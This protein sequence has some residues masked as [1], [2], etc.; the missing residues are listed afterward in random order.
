M[1]TLDSA[2]L[3]GTAPIAP[4]YAVAAPTQHMGMGPNDIQSG[5][6]GLV[7][8][9]N[10]LVWVGVFMLATVGLASVAGSVRLGKAKIT[11]QVGSG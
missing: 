2:T 4:S 9:R 1:R 3:Y 5:I 10:P 7:D 11:A 8:P 6:K